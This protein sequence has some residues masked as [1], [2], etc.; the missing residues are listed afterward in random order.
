VRAKQEQALVHANTFG[1]I[2]NDYFDRKLAKQRSGKAIGKRIENNLL[3]I[4]K[5][6]RVLALRLNFLF[7][8][9]LVVRTFRTLSLFSLHGLS[10]TT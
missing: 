6:L 8:A 3:P 9:T 4:F 1:A 5:D 2:A 10:P 7:E